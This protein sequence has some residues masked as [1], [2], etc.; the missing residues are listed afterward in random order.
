[1]FAFLVIYAA[2]YHV[3]HRVLTSAAL[4]IG[5][6]MIFEADH[7]FPIYATEHLKLF[8]NITFAVFLPVALFLVSALAE[9]RYSDLTGVRDSR[10]Q[11]MFLMV[12]LVGTSHIMLDLLDG[13]EEY[14]LYPF[15]RTP[16]VLNSSI[17]ISYSPFINL[18]AWFIFLLAYGLLVL[19]VRSFEERIYLSMEGAMGDS[20]AETGGRWSYIGGNLFYTHLSRFLSL[21]RVTRAE[22]RL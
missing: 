2:G 16:F 6:N 14:I 5:V 8:H 20:G 12:L 19:I 11:R 4:A 9:N 21:S 17:S 15:V 10:Y 7:L 13:S 1:M 22:N 3:R 18:D